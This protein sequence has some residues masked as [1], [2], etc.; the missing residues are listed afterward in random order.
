M[1]EIRIKS[2]SR[3][4]LKGSRSL[5]FCQNWNE[6]IPFQTAKSIV[7]SVS[8]SEPRSEHFSFMI[9]ITRPSAQLFGDFVSSFPEYKFIDGKHLHREIITAT[10][11]KVKLKSL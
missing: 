9:I 2:E 11:N 10:S 4:W 3:G 8:A 7:K 6:R 1:A 5:G